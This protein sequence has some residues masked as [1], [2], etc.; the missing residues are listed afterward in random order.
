MPPSYALIVYVYLTMK[1]MML[2]ES[3]QVLSNESP[4]MGAHNEDL[5]YTASEQAENMAIPDAHPSWV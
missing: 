1:A 5:T 4:P 2:K 3:I